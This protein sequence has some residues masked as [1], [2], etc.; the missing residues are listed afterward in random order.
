MMVHLA[1]LS[2]GELAMH[3]ASAAHRQWIG[4]TA[5]GDW[6]VVAHLAFFFF[7]LGC[8]G[9]ATWSIWRRTTKPAPHLQL[10]MEMADADSNEEARRPSG[11]AAKG[12]M[13]EAQP[14][15]RPE[16][17]WKRGEG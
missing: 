5:A 10:L 8:L 9:W 14:W 2:A 13:S 6:F 4:E 16:D 7:L 12:G 17:W 3:G 1:T 15:E 11:L